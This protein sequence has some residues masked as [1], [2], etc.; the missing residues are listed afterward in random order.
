[1]AG[2]RLFNVIRSPAAL[3]TAFAEMVKRL[4]EALGHPQTHGDPLLDGRTLI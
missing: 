1:M 2:A 3:Q 4:L